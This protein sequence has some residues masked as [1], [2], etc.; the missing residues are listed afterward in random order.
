MPHLTATDLGTIENL[1]RESLE[2]LAEGKIS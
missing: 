2:N 1:V